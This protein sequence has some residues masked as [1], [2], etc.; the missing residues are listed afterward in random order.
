MFGFDVG[1]AALH[2]RYVHYYGATENALLPAA[3]WLLFGVGAFLAAAFLES[4]R[5]FLGNGPV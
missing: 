2:P 4:R 5:V 1:C 3:A